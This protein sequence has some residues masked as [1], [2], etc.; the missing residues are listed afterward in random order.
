VGIRR[1]QAAV[2]KAVSS[3]VK[4]RG[5]YVLEDE[6]LSTGISAQAVI[7]SGASTIILPRKH[8]RSIDNYGSI[9]FKIDKSV[10]RLLL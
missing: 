4:Y 2:R 3:P 5:Q 9:W 10:T 6:A 8:R 1:L 7:E